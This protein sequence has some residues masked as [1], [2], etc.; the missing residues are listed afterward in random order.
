MLG[1]HCSFGLN[2]LISYALD[3]GC[4]RCVD[5]IWDPDG[6]DDWTWDE[7]YCSQCSRRMVP[8]W[9]QEFVEEVDNET[10]EEVVE[11]FLPNSD[12]RVFTTVFS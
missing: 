8:C 5:K 10:R 6:E 12:K 9:P 4:E 11:D 7:F 3:E 1:K 2:L